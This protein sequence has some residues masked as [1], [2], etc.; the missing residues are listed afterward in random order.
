MGT[1]LS[2]VNVGSFSIR[3]SFEKKEKKRKKKKKEE[4]GTE[5]VR[6]GV[7]EG[8]GRKEGV[9]KGLAGRECVREWQEG[10][11]GRKDEQFFPRRKC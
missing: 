1:V 3:C 2:L 10:L 5:C 4:R 7:R 9:R 6:D 8:V 11:E